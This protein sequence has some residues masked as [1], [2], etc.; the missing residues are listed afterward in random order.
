MRHATPAAPGWHDRTWR[1]NARPSLPSGAGALLA[2]ALALPGMLPAGAAAQSVHDHGVVELKYL[3]YRDWQSGADR[4]TVQSPTLYALVPIDDTLE[5]EGSVVYDA[6][7][8]ASPLFFNALSGASRQGVGDYRIA[9]EA[10]ATKYFNGWSLSVGGVASSE[11]DYLSRGGGVDLRIFSDDRNRTYAFGFAGTSDRLNP[12][13]GLVSNAPR[14]TVEFLFGITQA[15]SP[16]SIVNSNVTYSHGHGYY[17]DPYKTF[18]HRPSER[19]VFAW[20]TRYNEY[21]ATQDATLRLSYRL[22][23]DSWGSVS[24][25]FSAAW[26]QPLPQGFSVTPELRYYTQSSADFYYRPAARQRARV[27]RPLYGRHAARRVRCVHARPRRC[28][29]V[30]RRLDRR[31]PRRLLPP[32][33]ELA[34][35]RRQSGYPAVF[36]ALDHRGHHQEFLTRADGPATGGLQCKCRS[37]AQ[38]FA[39]WPRTTSCSSSRPTRCWRAAPRTPPSPT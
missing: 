9:G 3:N 13:N 20:L 29:V 11:Q 25:T 19:N 6:M 17:D 15:L 35:R 33:V 4:M 28:E 10:K 27:R 7:S 1:T 22:L 12:T 34:D 36:G 18:D 16:T 2:A 31:R 14:N 32:A 23:T 24:N 8:G 21:F 30:R 38:A 5:V 39:Q 37:S 26:V